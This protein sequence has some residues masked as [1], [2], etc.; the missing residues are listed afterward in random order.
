MSSKIALAEINCLKDS[1]LKG[2]FLQND[3]HMQQSNRSSAVVTVQTL[4]VIDISPLVVSL[5]LVGAF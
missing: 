2:S 4:V 5:Q 1:F 3:S